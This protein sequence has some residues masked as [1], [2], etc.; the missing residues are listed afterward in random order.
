MVLEDNF[1]SLLEHKYTIEKGKLLEKNNSFSF[2]C[3]AS[4]SVNRKTNKD[5][6]LKHYRERSKEHRTQILYTKKNTRVYY[7]DADLLE[8]LIQIKDASIRECI[9]D[10]FMKWPYEKK[11][12]GA[13]CIFNKN[14]SFNAIEI[15]QYPI[16]LVDYHD[17]ELSLNDLFYIINFVIAKDIYVSRISKSGY[18]FDRRTINKYT[19]LLL[20]YWYKDTSVKKQ[21]IEIGY[22]I[23]LSI[24][25][26]YKNNKKGDHDRVFKMNM[27]FETIQLPMIN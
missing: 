8:M 9:L 24:I 14:F 26:N 12:E 7:S 23:N 19:A 5:F 2:Y 20:W 21:L 17:L 18:K 16:D 4:L 11:H 27:A 25:E 13:V 1:I 6:E 10:T 3:P 15:P 22:N